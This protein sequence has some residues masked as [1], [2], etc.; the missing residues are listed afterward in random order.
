MSCRLFVTGLESSCPYE[1]RVEKT[2]RLSLLRKSAS[3]ERKMKIQDVVLPLTIQSVDGNTIPY[4]FSAAGL[5]FSY[6][7]AFIEILMP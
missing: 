6:G 5:G 3:L 2:K 7:A 4:I 1:N